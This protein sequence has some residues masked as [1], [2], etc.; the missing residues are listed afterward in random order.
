MGSPKFAGIVHVEI[1]IFVL[2]AVS[3]S[4]ICDNGRVPGWFKL[5]QL[6]QLIRL[7]IKLK[8]FTNKNLRVANNTVNPPPLQSNTLYFLDE[9]RG[10]LR[11]RVWRAAFPCNLRISQVVLF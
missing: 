11:N 10:P 3:L 4:L 2:S 8:Y 9:N 6:G 1:I 5:I 7:K